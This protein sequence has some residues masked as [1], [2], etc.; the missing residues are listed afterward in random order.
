MATTP[1]RDPVTLY[2]TLGE[3]LS[4]WLW[5]V[6]PLLLI[7]HYIVLAILGFVAS[8]TW[9]IT[10]FAIL[11]TGRYPRGLFDFHMGV[12]RWTWRVEFYGFQGLATDVYPPFQFSGPIDYP[13][14]IEIEY[15]ENLNRWLVLIKLFLAIPHLVILTILRGG[16]NGLSTL[17]VFIAG[18]ILLFTGKYPKGIFDLLMGVHIWWYR[19]IAYVA[20]M[21]DRYPPFRLDVP[22]P[23]AHR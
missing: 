3:P 22:P 4:R 20:F 14:D 8:I 5:I 10:L 19:T 6:K 17:L 11:F 1:D 16:E 13:A 23:L 12:F 9:V 2:A 21:T 18:I 15:P 7:P